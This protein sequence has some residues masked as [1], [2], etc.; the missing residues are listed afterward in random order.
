MFCQNQYSYSDGH[1]KG[2][3]AIVKFLKGTVSVIDIDISVPFLKDNFDN[4]YFFLL[5]KQKNHLCFVCE[6][7]P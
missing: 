1:F 5:H 4:C 6:P 3:K 2:K 7:T